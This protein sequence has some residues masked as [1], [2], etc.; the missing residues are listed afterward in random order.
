MTNEKIIIEGVEYSPEE[1]EEIYAELMKPTPT[2]SDPPKDRKF[3]K[4][5]FLTNDDFGKEV[6]NLVIAKYSDIE[7]I[8]KIGLG[9]GS[10]PFYVVAVNEVLR[11]KFPKIRTA[12][13]ADLE[14]ILREG[15]LELKGHY[16]DSGL[17]WRSNQDPNEYLAKNLYNQFKAKGVNLKQNSAYL[18]QLQNLSLKKDGASPEKLS[19]VMPNSITG[20]YFEAPILDEASQ[21]YFESSDVDVA[22]GITKKVSATGSRKLY[23]RNWNEYSVKNSGLVGACLGRSLDFYSN[24]DGLPGSND[25]G[26]VA[27]VS[28][29]GDAP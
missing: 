11:E 16:E 4:A 23:T 14:K 10:N 22:T 3:G 20:E 19:F 26:R 25:G 9:Q 8:K 28:A 5:F 1:L 12:T 2:P 17:V 24:D 7:A 15:S 29:E 6:H 27:L 13:Q 21:Q 18:I